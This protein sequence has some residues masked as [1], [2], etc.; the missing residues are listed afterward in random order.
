VSESL[1]LSLGMGNLKCYN[2]VMKLKY[3]FLIILLVALSTV[4]YTHKAIAASESSIIVNMTPGHPAPFEEV[5]ISLS[6]Y[7]NDLDSVNITWFVDGKNTSVGIGK[8]SF[9][10]NAP[11]TGGETVVT[12]IIALPEG[13]IEKR[14]IIRPSEMTLLWQANDSHTPPFYRGKALPTPESEIKIVA[15]PEIRSG[16]KMVAS[17]NMTYNW[18]KDYTKEVNG[19]GYGKNYFLYVHDYLDR[20]NTVSV[21]AST[22]DQ[23]YSNQAEISVSM[24]EPKIVFYENDPELGTRWERA[25]DGSFRIGESGII[26][27][28]PYFISPKE[29]YD[30]SLIWTWSLN[31]AQANV[32]ALSRNLMP[33]RTQAGVS[34]TSRLGLQIENRNSIFQSVSKEINIEF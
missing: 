6:S 9:L 28:V 14:I 32:S 10:F 13:S 19:S 31:G 1:K 26:E 7:V 17:K 33:L 23:K 5:R 15:I 12:V 3:S 4:S 2:H 8:K 20:S 11:K 21:V 25:L 22:L 27:A 24:R 30:P 16:G 29:T 18:E 34:G